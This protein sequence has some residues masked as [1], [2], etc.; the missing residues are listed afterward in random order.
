M[1]N[2]QTAEAAPRAGLVDFGLGMPGNS[3]LPTQILKEATAHAFEKIHPDLL[4]YGVAEGDGYFRVALAQFLSEQYGTEVDYNNLVVTNGNSQALDLICTLFTK[5]G[6]TIFVEEPSYFLAFDI[7]KDHGLNVISI[8]MEPDGI[9]LEALE[10]ELAT[11]K[12]AF[13]YTIPAFHNPT[14]IT[15]SKDKKLH[16]IEIA[17][18][19]GFYIA[20]DEVYQ[21]LY[22]SE[23]PP[24]PFALL[25]SS[26][27]ILSLGSFSKILAP[28]L[29][30]GWIQA[31]PD[32]I[33]R[34]G[35]TGFISSGGSVNHLMTGVVKSVIELGL[36]ERYLSRVKQTI[37]MRIEIMENI[38]REKMPES[39]SWK[40]PTGGYFFWLTLP[41]EI[42]TGAHL[43]L[44]DQLDTGYVPGVK[45]SSKNGLRN[46]LRLSSSYFDEQDLITGLDHFTDFIYRI[47]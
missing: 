39:I 19:E 32:L 20:A 3:I 42:D 28:G 17:E 31:N 22:Y 25:S 1:L 34:I 5:T 37:E 10:K 24:P 9:N 11:H 46:H 27:R 21:L 36:Q 7:F 6:D 15:M 40:T 43:N 14:G 47:I 16:L 38:L 13:L 30:L 33:K 18:R 45:F 8:P 29:R 44:A 2:L 23:P 12:P 4:S 41:K 35:L 26:N